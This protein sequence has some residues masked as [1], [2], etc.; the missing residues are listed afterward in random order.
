LKPD[1]AELVYTVERAARNRAL[2]TRAGGGEAAITLLEWSR[3]RSVSWT[4]VARAILTDA[5]VEPPVRKL[6][7]D[8]GRFLFTPAGR[9]RTVSGADIGE[10][11]SSWSLPRFPGE[12]LR[13]ER[14]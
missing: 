8:Y 7:Q 2:V 5:L 3:L 12:T 14:R 10:W 4:V 13:G 11:I 6:A 1:A 9:T